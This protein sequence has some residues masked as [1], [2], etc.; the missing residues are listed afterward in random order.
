[1][2]T[3]AACGLAV[4]GVKVTT[5]YAWFFPPALTQFG[6]ADEIM[7]T[8]AVNIFNNWIRMEEGINW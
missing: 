1:V 6:I 7:N 2:S 3:E 5:N 8:T 4:L